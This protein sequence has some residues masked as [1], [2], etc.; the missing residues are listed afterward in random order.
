MPTTSP[1]KGKPPQRLAR[2]VRLFEKTILMLTSWT[3][4][5]SAGFQKYHSGSDDP[6]VI[7]RSIDTFGRLFLAAVLDVRGRRC[8]KG[9]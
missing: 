7:I 8:Q 5:G 9:A 3:L 2:L 1:V 6:W 4:P